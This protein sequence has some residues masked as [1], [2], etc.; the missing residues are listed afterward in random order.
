MIDLT[1]YKNPCLCYRR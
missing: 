1:K